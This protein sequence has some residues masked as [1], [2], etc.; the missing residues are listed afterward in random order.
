[1]NPEWAATQNYNRLKQIED[2]EQLSLGEMAQKVQISAFPDAY[3]QWINEARA[4]FKGAQFTTVPGGDV[5]KKRSKMVRFANNQLGE[6]YVFGATGPNSWDCSGL[7]MAAAAKIGKQLAHSASIQ[8]MQ[9]KTIP[10]NMAMAG[11]LAFFNPGPNAAGDGTAGHVALMTGNKTFTHAAS[12]LLGVT[13]GNLDTTTNEF[14]KI[15]RL[16][17]LRTGGK[18]NYDNTIANLHRG[19]TVLTRPL[20]DKLEKNIASHGDSVYNVNVTVNNPSSELDVKRAVLDAM[21]ERE[22]R[23]GRNRKV[24]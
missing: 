17:G 13:T 19:E 24:N 9:T 15:G 14:I 22:I 10:T 20:T 1:M 18:I 4:I 12:P 16:P 23:L 21:R 3:D 8:Q 5:G 11:D 2:R 6:D 7:T